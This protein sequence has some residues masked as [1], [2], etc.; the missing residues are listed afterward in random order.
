MNEIIKF[1]ASLLTIYHQCSSV[2]ECFY[3]SNYVLAVGICTT[4]N[5]YF[6]FLNLSQPWDPAPELV[7]R[8]MLLDA[9]PY[10]YARLTGTN[11]MLTQFDIN[12]MWANLQK[13]LD[14][15]ET[16]HITF[17]EF[18][19]VNAFINQLTQTISEEYGT[20]FILLGM[21]VRNHD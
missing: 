16:Q 2:S 18:H 11:R 17:N 21:A 4:C 10:I 13:A 14:Y 5:N 8:Q 19:K 15:K 3:V 6:F 1:L 20:R 12:Y 9:L 7:S